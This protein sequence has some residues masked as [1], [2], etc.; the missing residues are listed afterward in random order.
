M[1]CTEFDLLDTEKIQDNLNTKRIGRKVIVYN[2]TSSTN[3]IARRYATDINNDGL[4]IFTEEQTSGRGRSGNIWHSSR[5][6]SILCSIIL[7]PL[8]IDTELLSLVTA[9]AAAEAIGKPGR[10]HAKI[11]WPNDIILNNKKVAGIL[12]ET[13][14]INHKS[15]CI[16]GI[17]I[18]CHQKENS[19][20]PDIKNIAT[21]I[22]IE[23]GSRIERN[24]LVKRLLTS[25][26]HC[27]ELAQHDADSIIRLWKQL[28]I[29]L[30]HRVTLIFNGKKFSGYCLGVDPQSGLIL[31][32]DTGGI[33]MFDAAHTTIVK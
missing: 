29:Q 21:S 22:D 3:D 1:T 7:N 32:L 2:N 11:K 19:F 24:A 14:S 12:L 33:R 27:Y 26:D 9:V 18:N 15:V 13:I 6:D 28:S 20:P 17:G 10:L 16:I 5:S 25:I 8:N 4:A 30:G 23:S 31:Q